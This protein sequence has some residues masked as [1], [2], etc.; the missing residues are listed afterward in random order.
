MSNTNLTRR[1]FLTGCSAA[2]AAMAGAR[3]S[4]IALANPLTAPSVD[5]D[6]LVT[7]FLR[8]GW[9]AL[10]VM[11]PIGGAD[12][13]YYE[14]AREDI[15][16][17]VSGEGAAIPLAGTLGLHPSMGPVHNLYQAGKLAIVQAAGLTSDTRSHFDA[18]NYMELGTPD[19]NSTSTGWITRHLQTAPFLP[20]SILFPALSAGSNQAT[21]LLG[22]NE[23]VAMSDP[24]N[25]GFS[26]HWE[27]ENLQRSALR[28]LYDGDTWLYQSGTQTLNAVDIIEGANPGGYTP[29]N[30][31]V[32]PDTSFGDNLQAIAQMIKM[33]LGLSAATVDLGGWDTHQ[34]QGEGS[35]GYLS[36]KLDD[37]ARGLAAFYLDLDS[38][39]TGRLIVVVKSE[40][41]RR[42][43][44]NANRGTDHGHGSLMVVMGGFVNGGQLYGSWPGLRNDQLYDGADL[45]VTTDYRRVLSEIL[46]KRLANPNMDQV[47]PGYTG[48]QDMGIVQA[49]PI[50]TETVYLPVSI[51]NAP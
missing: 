5:S 18:M 45:D 51:R 19:D 8:G 27:Y 2:I 40:F 46:I 36:T 10:N 38:G 3:I 15:Q 28:H 6:I 13:G 35:G 14:A 48:Y 33:N 24:D 31:A 12:R 26:G 29:S 16:V 30:G 1:E 7:V 21:S 4:R 23:A 32:Y 20:E 11:M 49:N 43:R 25:F 47:F 42:L 44:E 17:P 50:F 39:Y 37:L 34:N 22:S 41:G 9:D